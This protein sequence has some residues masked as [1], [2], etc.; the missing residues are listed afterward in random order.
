MDREE[1]RVTRC[2]G[3]APDITQWAG[4]DADNLTFCQSAYSYVCG[5][6]GCVV[7][8][9][10]AD[11]HWQTNRPFCAN[12]CTWSRCLEPEPA[13]DGSA[14]LVWC[15]QPG[16]MF[17]PVGGLAEQCPARNECGRPQ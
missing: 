5:V 14:E 17:P 4:W 8:E 12:G 10:F 11:W 15:D 9:Q 6:C 7:E 16:W 13:C 2:F 3:A 1:V